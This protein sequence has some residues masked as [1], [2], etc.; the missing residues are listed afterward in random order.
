MNVIAVIARI[1]LGLVFVFFGSNGFL[2][3]IPMQPM[4]GHAGEF[5]GAMYAT[6]YLQV[7]AACQIIGGALLLVGRFVP[8]GLTLLGPIVVNI[9]LFHAFLE[10]SGMLI[11]LIVFV[12]WLFLLWRYREAFAGLTRP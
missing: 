10:R 5:I 12:I 6:G 1:L 3:F 8:L 11:A 7:I 4:S 2:H 9:V